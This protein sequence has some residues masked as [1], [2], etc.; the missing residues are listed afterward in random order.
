M[1]KLGILFDIG[2][3]EGGLYGYAAYQI[4]F[5]AV[6]TR[7]LAGCTL[8]DGDTNATLAGRANQYC[9]AVEALDASKIAA[10]RSAMSRSDA[11]GL[12]P[13]ASRFLESALAST[14]PTGEQK[15]DKPSPK[16]PWWQFWKYP[17]HLLLLKAVG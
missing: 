14:S 16:K 3:L 2:D 7:Q 8:S 15:E 4:F 10:V 9:V 1:D 13:P 12:L 6:D 17:H 11:K 5:G